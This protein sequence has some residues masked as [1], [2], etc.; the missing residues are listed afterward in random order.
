ME[1]PKIKL[2][3]TGLIVSVE[4][5]KCRFYAE[6]LFRNLPDKFEKPDIRPLLN[7]SW[8]QNLTK[9]RYIQRKIGGRIW[10]LKKKCVVF[11]NGEYLGDD[12]DFFA[13]IM[14]IARIRVGVD[15]HEMGIRHL[16]TVYD[17]NIRDGVSIKCILWKRIVK[18]SWLQVGGFD[19][20][21]KRMP[22]ENYIIPHNRRGVLSMCNG[23][24]HKRNNVQFIISLDSTPWMDYKY[25]AFGQVVQGE[26]VL[27]T[28]EQVPTRYEFPKSNISIVL[29]N[30][31]QFQLKPDPQDVEDMA[32]YEQTADPIKYTPVDFECVDDVDSNISISKFLNGDYCL[33]TDLKSNMD[34][35]QL[36]S[37]LLRLYM[38]YT[39]TCSPDLY[40]HDEGE[41]DHDSPPSTP[42]DPVPIIE[43][44]QYKTSVQL[45]MSQ[46][47]KHDEEVDEVEVVQKITQFEQD[48]MRNQSLMPT[49][50]EILHMDDLNTLFV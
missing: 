49:S 43:T 26:E 16:K 9:V 35:M 47:E 19:L 38:E 31:Y 7:V 13:F 37:F 23:G 29:C 42:T 5:Q 25:V 41:Q 40:A 2:M 24:K 14:N 30:E 18:G 11:I 4:F 20:N 46:N 3:I 21:W 15:F 32:K 10:K 36:P 8:Q 44:V 45:K 39:G 17:K 6:R 28:I 48:D 22:C 34:M 33:D 50:S 1:E 27:S 12:D